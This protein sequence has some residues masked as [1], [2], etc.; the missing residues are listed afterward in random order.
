MTSNSPLCVAEGSSIGLTYDGKELVERIVCIYGE[1]FP[2]ELRVVD[3][4]GGDE[5]AEVQ[6]QWLATLSEASS[7]ILS[8]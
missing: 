2:F 4:F 1:G 6:A 7:S 5:V 3:G 8:L